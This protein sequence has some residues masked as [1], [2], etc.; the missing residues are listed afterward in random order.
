[1]ETVASDSRPPALAPDHLGVDFDRMRL[2]V[3]NAANRMDGLSLLGSIAP[4]SVAAVFF[5][6]QYRG[7]LDRMSY[8]NEGARQLGRVALSQMTEDVIR[9]FLAAIDRVLRP[10]GYLFLWVDKFHLV[11]GTSHWFEGT[12]LRAVDLVTWN[13]G[14]IGMGYRTRRKCEYLMV[15]QREPKVARATW[16]RRDIPD[17]WLESVPLKGRHPHG[18]P[19]LLQAALV[20]ASTRPGDIV[21]DPA[22]GGY[23]VLEAVRKVGEGRVF[24]GCDL[25]N[26]FAPAVV[27]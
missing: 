9:S 16:S 6:P 5:D 14:R 4:A 19:A 10:S 3:P 25:G 1:M 8:G 23:A 27:P 7:V 13:K 22:A 11:E 18:K 12:A 21:V 2:V 17:V 26:E 20:E 15:L 24:L